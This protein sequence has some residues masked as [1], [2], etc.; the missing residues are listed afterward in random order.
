MS[1]QHKGVGMEK[2]LAVPGE[3]A[4]WQRPKFRKIDLRE[5][6]F[7]FAGSSDISATFS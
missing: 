2:K 7:T 5:S 4:E 6:E 3:R 1:E